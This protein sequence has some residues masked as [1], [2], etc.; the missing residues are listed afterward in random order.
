MKE[1]QQIISAAR[2]AIAATSSIADLEQAKARFLGQ[3]EAGLRALAPRREEAGT[4]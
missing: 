2:E 3:I 4:A 1:L